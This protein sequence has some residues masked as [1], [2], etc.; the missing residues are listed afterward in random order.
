MSNSVRRVPQIYFPLSRPTSSQTTTEHRSTRQSAYPAQGRQSMRETGA[1]GPARRGQQ[2]QEVDPRG[3]AQPV[4]LPMG[5]LDRISC[6]S[7]H[8][9]RPR[10]FLPVFRSISSLRHVPLPCRHLHLHVLSNDLCSEKMKHKK[11][12]NS[13]HPHLGFFLHLHEVLSWFDEEPSYFERVCFGPMSRPSIHIPQLASTPT[14]VPTQE[15]RV[16]ASSQRDLVLLEMRTGHE[17]HAAAESPPARRVGQR[18]AQGKGQ[19]REETQARRC[20]VCQPRYIGRQGQGRGTGAQEAFSERLIAHGV[21]S[22]VFSSLLSPTTWLMKPRP[23]YIFVFTTD[24]ADRR[25]GP[26]D[27]FVQCVSPAFNVIYPH[28]ITDPWSCLT[29]T[30]Q[31]LYKLI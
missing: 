24:R 22:L 23:R 12:Y 31:R 10:A 17:E 14:D 29:R 6:N 7:E 2:R 5:D 1:L 20:G 27:H 3:D 21:L 4:R 19:A 26:C 13:Y 28:S 30:C 8:G 18:S 9:V 11:H 25:V 15:E 16:R